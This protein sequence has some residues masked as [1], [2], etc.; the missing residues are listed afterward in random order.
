MSL[1]EFKNKK[2]FVAHGEKIDQMLLIK[3]NSIILTTSGDKKLKVWSLEGEMNGSI[4]FFTFKKINWKVSEIN[5][6]KKIQAIETCIYAIKLIENRKFTPREEE[7]IKINLLM[8]EFMD[9]KEKSNYNTWIKVV[10][11]NRNSKIRLRP[12]TRGVN[13]S[14]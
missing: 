6:H 8:N 11:R 1:N 7:E 3:E 9:G 14:K 4:D 2:R 10:R 12:I 5:F 13:L